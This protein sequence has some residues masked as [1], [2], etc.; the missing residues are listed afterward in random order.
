M[1]GEQSPE[2][3]VTVSFARFLNSIVSAAR[4]LSEQCNLMGTS[5]ETLQSLERWTSTLAEATAQR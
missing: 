1:A 5:D 3:T 4:Q 2:R